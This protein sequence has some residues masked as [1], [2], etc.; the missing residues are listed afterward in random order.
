M[1][2]QRGGGAPHRGDEGPFDLCAGRGASGVH[3]AG[4]RVTALAG[5]LQVA[6]FVA[7]ELGTEGDE[8]LDASWAFVDQDAHRV[9]VAQTGAC[10]EG[11]G[12]VQVDLLRVARQRGGD[13]A[14]GPPGGGQVE[15]AL[16]DHAGPQSVC[17]G[18]LHSGREPR[19]AGAEHEQVEL[20]GVHD[21]LPDSGSTAVTSTAVTSTAGS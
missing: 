15:A 18:R 4:D 14:L 11:V 1:L 6:A 10:G 17:S 20:P 7:V 5:E 8:L 12:Q 3:D 19:H 9:D 16:G 13:A 2:V 21:V